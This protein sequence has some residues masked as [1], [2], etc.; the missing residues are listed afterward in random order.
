MS[1]TIRPIDWMMEEMV[2]SYVGEGSE[3]SLVSCPSSVLD[4]SWFNVVGVSQVSREKSNS[5]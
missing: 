3:Q 4:F 5:I 1:S 2:E